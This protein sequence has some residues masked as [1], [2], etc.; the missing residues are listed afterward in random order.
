MERVGSSVLLVEG[1]QHGKAGALA[2]LV[3]KYQRRIYRIAMQITRNHEDASDVTQETFLKVYESIYSLRRKAA[4]ETWIY[5]IAVNKATNLVKR[6]DRRCE[7]SLSVVC[8]HDA[9]FDFRRNSNLI[10]VPHLHVE[11]QELQKTVTQAVNSLSLKHRTVVV[12]YEFEGLTHVEIASI[13]GCLE[14]TVRSRLH[15]ARKQLR[16]R[17]KSYIDA[18][19]VDLR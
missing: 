10:N 3:H 8:E 15:Y 4:F 11:K 13:L 17:L 12:L 19:S 2:E 6:R 5:R 18:T 16:E 1:L 14:G 9:H 7:S